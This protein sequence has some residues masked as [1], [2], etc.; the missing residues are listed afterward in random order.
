MIAAQHPADPGG[1][2]TPGALT[3][4][5]VASDAA[6]PG[7]L[8]FGLTAVAYLLAGGLALLLAIP[9]GYASPLYPAAGVALASVL[10]FGPRMLPAVALG[11]FAVN[12]WI[13]LQRGPI[14]A[15]ALALPVVAAAGATLQA[16]FGA[17]LVK[18]FVQQP[19]TLSEPRD[20]AVFLCVNVVA[21]M[22]SAIVGSLA[23]WLMRAIPAGAVPL[24][25]A[26]WWIG[27]LL[28][29]VIATPV[30][31]TLF[32]RPRDAWV[33]RRLSV[34]LTLALVTTLLALGIRQVAN[35]QRD[36]EQTAFDH[37]ATNAAQALVTQLR[38]PL[39]ALEAL[40]GLFVAS[41][42]VARNEI[43][44][45]TQAW[46]A[47]GRLLAMGW[48]ERVAAENLPAFEAAAR[49]DGEARY[50]VFDRA[51]AASLPGPRTE[52]M[53]IRQIEPRAGNA[54]AMGV[55]VISIP[56][57]RLAM[58]TAVRSGQPAAT[59][60]FRLAQQAA[61]DNRIGVVIYQAVYA[62]P[63]PTA[64]RRA[65]ALRGAV[66]V[67][68][69]M[70]DQLGTLA[71]QLPRD[72]AVC[73]IDATPGEGARRLA[74]A[75]GCEVPRAGRRHVRDLGYAG[76]Q[77]QVQVAE[78]GPDGSAPDVAPHLG[79]DVWWFALVGLL[80]TATLGAFLLAL[81]G[82]TRRIETAV[83]ERTAA[84]RAEVR[85]RE[86]AEAALRE[87]EQ[88]IRNIL[89]NVPIGVIYTD[90]F[91]E[92][93]Q[94]NP[95]FCQLTGFAESELKGLNVADCTHPDDVA[96][97]HELRLQLVRGEIPRYR[98][99]KRYLTRGGAIL[100]AQV[101]VTV[102]RDAK[103]HASSI[104]AVVED[105]GEQLKLEAA[106]RARE[107]AE[108]SNQAK[109]EFL[110]RMSHEL[111]TPLNAMLGFAQLLELD[112]KHPLAP[113]QRP[114]VAQIQDA[115]WH[116]LEMINDVL[117][118]SRIESGNLSL[119]VQPVKLAEMLEPSIA[120]VSGEAQ[121]RRIDITRALGTGTL[122]V[123]GD[124][125]RIKQILT[126]LLSNAVKYNA[127]GGRVH[128]A[129]RLVG[130]DT[131][132]ISVTDTGLG[133]TPEQLG[134]LFQPFNRLGRERSSQEGTGIGLVI[135]QRLAESMGGSLHA[136]SRA[137]EGSMFTLTL[138]C[139]VEI[140]T[141][142]SE[143][144]ELA[145]EPA[146]YHRRRV[147]Y[148]EDNATNVEVMRG[149]LAQRPQVELQVA[150]DGREALAVLET[151]QPDLILLDMHLP[152]ISGLELLRRFRATRRLG[153]VPIVMVSADALEP[154]IEA[155]YEAGC[156]RYLTKPVNV[157]ELL[158]VVDHILEPL[159]TTFN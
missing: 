89:D 98:R 55:N 2:T 134:A 11:S 105:V 14:D 68:L 94:A 93:R 103:G 97:D 106:E 141:V 77:W 104:V 86:G 39:L 50:T 135:S 99:H 8:A 95:H 9:P 123:F 102:L 125:T 52:V 63:A 155:A 29:V 65:E 36:R 143:L 139:P 58:E 25:L 49:A 116:L 31:L 117:D 56:A 74:G 132:E 133:M 59:A 121:R 5:P 152:D 4:A 90:L 122:I 69:R 64:G 142:R 54:T 45:A 72:L 159:D 13:G 62:P 156:T 147:L 136:D 28:G 34:G 108:A 6:L 71:A 110:S 113:A 22:P 37:A 120:M 140:D 148:V 1:P 41:D 88:R 96:R 24:N 73:L 35:S 114:R 47:T 100:S 101:T 75:A 61:T 92:I 40:N 82:R 12:L 21:C 60:G 137:G 107:A 126:N 91:G 158:S 32:G 151:Q 78:S 83:L 10:M 46:L 124:P 129:S 145:L 19:L 27:D 144:D 15:T 7:P 138:P 119:Q 44:L 51:E 118:L 146:A 127:D 67:T 18:R 80:A 81:T 26:T 154:Q 3:A 42:G 57:A 115:G 43:R 66:F 23:L 53:A 76:R 157:I 33:P 70:D 84:L 112:P 30:L 150:A 130:A 149:I 128:I 16:W 131:V 85:E 48:V 38:E 109:S 79:F 20:I 111:R 87:T 153:D 17:A